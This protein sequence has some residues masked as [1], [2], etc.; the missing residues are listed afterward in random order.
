MKDKFALNKKQRKQGVLKASSEK[1]KEQRYYFRRLFWNSFWLE[2]RE[3]GSPICVLLANTTLQN[4]CC[5][6]LT[7]Y[8][9][10]NHLT[11]DSEF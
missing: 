11:V 5:T 1:E 6:G 7:L 2:Q 8:F 9:V 4:V 3:G 10:A